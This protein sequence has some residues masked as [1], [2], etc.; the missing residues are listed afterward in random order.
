MDRG[1]LREKQV[2]RNYLVSTT[3]IVALYFVLCQVLSKGGL[4]SN[5]TKLINIVSNIMQTIVI[6]AVAFGMV[7]LRQHGQKFEGVSGEIEQSPLYSRLKR[8]LIVFMMFSLPFTVVNWY[9]VSAAGDAAETIPDALLGIT[10]LLYFASG[11]FFALVMVASQDC[12]TACM[13]SRDATRTRSRYGDWAASV[14]HAPMQ[15]PVFVNTD[16]E[17]SS[18][19][20]GQLGQT[21]HAAQEL[22]DDLLRSLLVKHQGYEITTCG[23]A[24]QLAF[25]SIPDAVAYCLDVQ[26]QLLHV[27]WPIELIESYLA[28]SITVAMPKPSVLPTRHKHPYLFR[29]LRVRMGIHASSS[30][31][32]QLF[33]NVHPVTQRTTYVGLAEMIGREV[34][35]LGSGG[36]IIVTARVARFLR[37][38]IES[39]DGWWHENPCLMQDLGVYR[40]N[41][42]KID[43]GIAEVVPL[44]L[45]D[46]ARLF[47]EIGNVRSRKS[48]RRHDST[49]YDLL[50]SPA[51]PCES[52]RGV[53]C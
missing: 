51:D 23:D 39:Q 34:S 31:E 53:E 47:P 49:A 15:N 20:W 19:L 45:K 8:I 42:L 33:T 44:A 41:D 50:M 37:D 17:S 26:L 13:R 30:E 5:N 14:A 7:S 48:Y 11:L 46:R 4:F 22:H 52:L 18:Y 9:G 2:R 38:K 32:G 35:D 10:Q 16:I 21:M 28:G 6:I 3:L 40:I 12:C 43:L 1:P 24:F 27:P 25:H 29:G 36:Q